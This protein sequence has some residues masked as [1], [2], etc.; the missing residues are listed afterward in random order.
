[1]GSRRIL[2]LLPLL[3]LSAMP[4]LTGC[5]ESAS[6]A[7][8]VK[9]SGVAWLTQDQVRSA[10][11]E[12][13]QAAEHA[14]DIVV[15]TTGRVAF[16]DQRVAHVYSPVTGRVVTVD[17]ALG[18]RVKRGAALATIVS[19]EVGQWS[20]DLHRADADLVAAEHDFKRKSELLAVKAVAQAD[21]DASEDAYRQAKAEKDRAE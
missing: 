6:A 11:I 20:S 12:V 9:E 14:V 8:P 13:A 5:R 15:A 16:D 21:Y 19:P 18:Q 2:P 4:A 3:A 10:K 1:M 7:E 17:A